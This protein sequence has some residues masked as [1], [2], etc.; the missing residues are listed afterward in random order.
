MFEFF[1]PV[2]DH[3]D[4]QA[5]QVTSAM[6]AGVNNHIRSVDEIVALLA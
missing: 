2:E 4:G 3:R 1:E 5:R 6:E